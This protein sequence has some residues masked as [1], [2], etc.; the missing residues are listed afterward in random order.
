MAGRRHDIDAGQHGTALLPCLEAPLHGSEL[1]RRPAVRPDHEPLPVAAVAAVGGVGKDDGALLGGPPDVVEV[2]V[3]EDHVGDVGRRDVHAGQ[4][5]DQATALEDP[6]VEG[7]EAGVDEH[8]AIAGPQEKPAE[9]QLQHA[10]GIEEP[11]V[12]L[13][14]G[15]RRPFEGL[16]RRH[17]GHAVDDRMD[18]DI[19]DL[20]ALHRIFAYL[21]LAA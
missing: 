16:P 7:P 12:R 13:P 17:M 5:L 15:R 21:Y 3:G 4:A 9:G 8:G 11:T 18:R 2:E 19:A 20:H 1:A 14:I 10:L 6:G